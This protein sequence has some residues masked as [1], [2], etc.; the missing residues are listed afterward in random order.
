[1]RKDRKPSPSMRHKSRVP[2]KEAV[3]SQERSCSGWGWGCIWRVLREH[4]EGGASRTWGG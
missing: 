2:A 3:D 4:E 1:M